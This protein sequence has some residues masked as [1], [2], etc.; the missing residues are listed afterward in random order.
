MQLPAEPSAGQPLTAQW[1]AQ[2]VRYLRAITP[3]AS[4]DVMPSVG[5]GGATFSLRARRAGGGANI[6]P[7]F[8]PIDATTQEGEGE[9][10]R[11]VRITYGLVCGEAP[12]GMSL[13][14]SPPYV[15]PLAGSAGHV[16]LVI[17]LDEED[18]IDSVSIDSAAERPADAHPI[19]HHTICTW[20]VD[21]TGFHL[22][23]ALLGS[24]WFELCGGVEAVWRAV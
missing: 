13:G 2:V 15:L 20:A 19:Y 8:Y 12:D 18:T 3:R 21:D 4:A 9:P 6:Y 7:S 16:Y 24:Q 23:P 14:D 5:A 11:K 17:S 1:C 10:V 22:A